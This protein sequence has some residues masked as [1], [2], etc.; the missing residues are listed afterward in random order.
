VRIE[1]TISLRAPE[2][3]LT[4]L[5]E[6]RDG[7][8]VLFSGTQEIIARPGQS[9]GGEGEP[10]EVTYTGPGADAVSLSVAP[11]EQSIMTTDSIDFVASAVNASQQSV[12]V[13]AIAWSV[14][15]PSRGTVSATGRFKPSQTRGSTNVIAKLPTGI[16]AQAIVTITPVASQIVV[17]SGGDQNGVVGTALAQPIVVEVRA[18]DN[19]PVSGVPITFAVTAGGG[20]ITTTNATTDANG[21]AS[22]SLTLGTVA[23][24]NSV[25]AT[26]ANVTPRTVNATANPGAAAGLAMVQQPSATATSGVALGT[27]PRVRLLDAFGNSVATSGVQITAAVVSQDPITLSGTA[28]VA[29]DANGVANFTDLALVGLGGNATLSFSGASLTSA[30]SSS[31][32]LSPSGTPTLTLETSG[33]ITAEAG[34]AIAIPPSVL[35]R[36]AN[37]TRRTRAARSRSG[38]PCRTPPPRVWRSSRSRRVWRELRG[39]CWPTSTSSCTTRSTISSRRA[40]PRRPTSRCRWRPV[41]RARCS[42]P[43]RRR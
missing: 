25:T 15:D 6:L 12:P 8:V 5:V 2:E 40:R 14:Q 13:V 1:L 21:R 43:I 4:A 32:A 38:S 27:Q 41:R 19:L 22:T 23:G 39:R 18:F 9:S 17:A 34:T 42:V 30:T 35:V 7:T 10:L 11:A 33:E 20:S 28:T 24:G 31:I 37:G 36:D 26:V 29:T 16:T 3:L